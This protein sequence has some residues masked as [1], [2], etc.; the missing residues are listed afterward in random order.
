MDRDRQAMDGTDALIEMVAL[1]D[2]F[3]GMEPW[4]FEACA[5]ARE[6]RALIEERAI[7][8]SKRNMDGRSPFIKERSK[9]SFGL[10]PFD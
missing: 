4:E 2:A 1:R 8:A 6:C 9:A 5:T 10:W 7:G 3:L